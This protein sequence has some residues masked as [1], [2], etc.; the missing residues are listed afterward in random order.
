MVGKPG[1]EQVRGEHLTLGLHAHRRPGRQVQ[2]PVGRRHVDLR[3]HA[4]RAG[5]RPPLVVHRRRRRQVG[6]L[7][8]PTSKS[9]TGEPRDSWR[10]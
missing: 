3:R 9:S 4:P 10:G 7:I 6:S 1:G 5:G 8:I 2:G